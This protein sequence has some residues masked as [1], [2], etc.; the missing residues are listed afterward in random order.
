VE[1]AKSRK[2]ETDLQREQFNWNKKQTM[3]ADVNYADDE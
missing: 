2:M 1:F 3:S